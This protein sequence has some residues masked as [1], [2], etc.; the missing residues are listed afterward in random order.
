MPC[1]FRAILCSIA[2]ELSSAADPGGKVVLPEPNGG[3]LGLLLMAMFFLLLVSL[4]LSA[5]KAQKMRRLRRA[6]EKAKTD[7]F[8]LQCRLTTAE[9]SLLEEV[10]HASEEPLARVVKLVLCFDRG[11]DRYLE[12]LP[13]QAG[14]EH[15]LILRRLKTLRTKLALNRVLPG[16]T[17]VSTREISLGQV[18]LLRLSAEPKGKVFAGTLIDF[19]DAGL[20]VRLKGSE[21]IEAEPASTPASGPRSAFG[22]R[23]AKLEAYFL[24]Q[25]DGGYHFSTRIKAVLRGNETLFQLSHPRRLRRE[26]RRDYFRVPVRQEICF[27]IVGP[28]ILDDPPARHALEALKL[29]QAGTIVDMS[30]GGFRLVTEAASMQTDDLIAVR[31]HFLDESLDP[32]VLVARVIKVY[33]EGAEFGFSFETLSP[34]NRSVIVRYVEEVHRQVQCAV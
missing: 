5:L 11:V 27:R 31:L 22:E 32:K 2:D 10:V 9:R 3:L 7:S 23:G 21:P 4:A 18:F 12:S 17:L 1:D 26:Q 29:D 6:Q 19:D 25:N 33:R 30:G 14:D 13:L 15:L 28:E 16:V 34:G 24:R 8:L 20:L